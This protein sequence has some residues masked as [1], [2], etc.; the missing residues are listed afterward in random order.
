MCRLNVIRR[1]ECTDFAPIAKKNLGGYGIVVKVFHVLQ[2][3]VAVKFLVRTH[4]GDE[5]ACLVSP[6]SV[7]VREILLR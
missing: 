2:E 4:H 1:G 5:R 3:P 7:Y 6:S